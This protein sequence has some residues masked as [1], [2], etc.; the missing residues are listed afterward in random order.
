MQ[1]YANEQ[2]DAKVRYRGFVIESA[3][4][5]A[6]D[7]GTWI[8]RV[9]LILHRANHTD[10]FGQRSLLEEYRCRGKAVERSVEYGREW[11]NSLLS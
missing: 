5:Q 10:S 8:P 1:H 2:G 11:V 9:G 4:E 3:V 6:K 7:T